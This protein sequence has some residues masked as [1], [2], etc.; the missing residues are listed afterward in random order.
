MVVES[1]SS[2]CFLFI[3]NK[4]PDTVYRQTKRLKVMHHRITERQT[5]LLSRLL[6]RTI[7]ENWFYGLLARR[8]TN[9]DRHTKRFRNHFL[10]L[11][12]PNYII[13]ERVRC[14][15]VRACMCKKQNFINYNKQQ[16]K[17]NVREKK[18]VKIYT[19]R[20]DVAFIIIIAPW[21]H[22]SILF[23]ILF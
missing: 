23:F 8:T 21:V 14:V 22:R 5:N 3:E 6:D 2:S 4:M 15:C 7:I 12:F 1:I 9:D 10:C 19:H 18:E 20:R 13:A 17:M 16:F 11:L